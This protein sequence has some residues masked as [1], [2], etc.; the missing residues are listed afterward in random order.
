MEKYIDE[1]KEITD[2]LLEGRNLLSFVAKSPK[3]LFS[4]TWFINSADILKCVLL[5]CYSSFQGVCAGGWG[6]KT[7]C[8]Q[9]TWVYWRDKDNQ[10]ILLE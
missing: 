9:E 3:L 8:P 5:N 1:A 10:T 6:F 4:P 2:Y 7:D